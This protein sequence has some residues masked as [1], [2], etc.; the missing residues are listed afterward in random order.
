M[1]KNILLSGEDENFALEGLLSG[2]NSET[3]QKEWRLNAEKYME[4]K[5]CRSH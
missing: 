2:T 4:K 1:R 5:V 3:G